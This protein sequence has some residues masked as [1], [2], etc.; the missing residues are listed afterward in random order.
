MPNTHNKYFNSLIISALV[1]NYCQI[2][3]I[4]RQK[5]QETIKIK[6]YYCCL[7]FI[8]LLTGSQ[9]LYAQSRFSATAGWG[10]YELVNIG[11]QWNFTQISSLSL[12]GGANM[13]SWEKQ[14]WSA[15]LS[16]DQTFLK[17]IIWK[18]KPGYSIGAIYWTSNDDLYYFRNMA[19]PFM[20]LLAYPLSGSL[21]VRV[22]GGLVFNAVL[23]SDR[24]QNIEAGYP[25]RFNGNLRLSLI[26][27]FGKK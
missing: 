11:A 6:K 1:A 12:Y 22:E 25:D 27:K 4:L 10:Y 16:F 9:Y 20:A 17:P 3:I 7:L 23:Q 14:Q 19:F 15:G 26:Y 5:M 18:L 2:L 13:G 21:S 8:F 24:K